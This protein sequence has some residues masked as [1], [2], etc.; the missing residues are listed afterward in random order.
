MP[1]PHQATADA[2]PG[3]SGATEAAPSPP[4][5]A[6]GASAPRR[7]TS[8]AR[9]VLLRVATATLV[10]ALLLG[11]TELALRVAGVG[12]STTYLTPPDAAGVRRARPTFGARFFPPSQVRAT[13][14]LRVQTPKPPGTYRV[15]VLG[16]SA[17]QGAPD[18]AYSVAR[19]LEH[20][21]RQAAPTRRV[22]VFNVAVTAINSHAVR[23]I[24]SEVAALQPDLFVVYMGNNEVV[25]PFGVGDDVHA[26]VASLPLIR[27]TVW[28][29]GTRTGQLIAAARRQ[30]TPPRGAVWR[31]METFSRHRLAE[32]DPRMTTVVNHFR[33]NLE[34]IV[35]TGHAAGASVLLCTVPTNLSASPPFASG[36]GDADGRY[37]A[38]QALWRAGDVTR[39]W[40]AFTE[41]RDRDLVR[42][43]ADSRVNGVIRAVAG[44]VEPPSPG[45]R[46]V[47][48][49]AVVQRAAQAAK[50][51]PTHPL[52]WEHVHL[53]F[54]GTYAVA[55]A[56]A[57]PVLAAWG[58]DTAALPDLR[59]TGRAL[60]YTGWSEL[61]AAQWTAALMG[62]PPFTGQR[63]ATE[64]AAH[65][66]RYAE[67][68]RTSLS[69]RR[70]AAVDTAYA[71]A[72]AAR[73][74]D[75]LL[76]ARYGDF[77]L[78]ARAAPERA[79]PL[80]A[81]A[82]QAEPERADVHD[83]HAE[84][85]SRVGQPDAALRAAQA[86]FERSQPS[87]QAYGNLGVALARERRLTAAASAFH[88]ALALDPRHAWSHLHLAQV[89]ALQGELAAARAAAERALAL[90]PE[91]PGV[92]A[93][94]A[95][96]RGR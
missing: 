70:L 57:L 81:A 65:M 24:A 41:A 46:L 73:P 69:E 79:L 49:D 21:L 19:V 25:G 64:R 88:A 5:G 96:L 93:L 32:S 75:T 38:G 31:G 72:V 47:D 4:A 59:A 27:A 40:E 39:A 67:S 76:R 7:P 9:A 26:Q 90:Q 35:A 42:F 20:L 95:R 23:E 86:A 12:A 2:Q 43:R 52:L 14:P 91:L 1:P 30:L 71:A 60:V 92:R 82:A 61:E 3:A 56:L 89:L 10:P 84:A 8:R 58:L 17:A 29:R 53:R 78:R 33:A 68:V 62:R 45:L 11:A 37:A 66:R 28:L 44:E 13:V 85:L 77:L 51:G 94:V 80:L 83:R 6:R 50:P 55:K 15:F 63:H 16:G 18:A 34:A 22:E 54:E 74:D 36:E 87:P 48:L